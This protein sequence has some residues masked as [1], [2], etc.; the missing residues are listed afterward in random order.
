MHATTGCMYGRP[1][2]AHNTQCP[3]RVCIRSPAMLRPKVRPVKVVHLT[4]DA[5]DP[6]LHGG[7]S[8]SEVASGKGGS[9]GGKVASGSAPAVRYSGV[10]RRKPTAWDLEQAGKSASRGR[11]CGGTLKVP[12]TLRCQ[13]LKIPL[14]NSGSQ[15]RGGMPRHAP[16]VW[17]RCVVSPLRW[18]VRRL[19]VL[20]AGHR[21][22]AKRGV[23]CWGEVSTMTPDVCVSHV[24]ACQVDIRAATHQPADAPLQGVP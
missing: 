15:E 24:Q 5:Q 20:C 23:K 19:V 1:P 14:M 21:R 8:Y 13:T 12:S 2:A 4:G 17:A 22:A 18:I 9:N 3:L 11:R 7:S 16:C 10:L 6:S